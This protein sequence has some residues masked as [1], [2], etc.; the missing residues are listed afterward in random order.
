M[1]KFMNI[2][3]VSF[4]DICS[5]N[6]WVRVRMGNVLLVGFWELWG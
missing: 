4:W 2:I 3:F 5:E 6:K 1:G